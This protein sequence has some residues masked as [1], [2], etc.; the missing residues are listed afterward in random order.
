[1]VVEYRRA[2]PDD[3]AE[4]VVLRGLTRENAVPAERLA[5]AGIT[6]ESWAEDTRSGALVGHVCVVDAKIA[7]YCF[8]APQTGEV[9]VL[10]LLPP[11]EGQ[12]IGRKLLGFV[13]DDL[14]SAGFTRLFLGC[15]PDPATR[16]YGFYRHLGWRSTGT[17]NAS[18]DE[19][20]ETFV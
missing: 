11:F 12:R 15:S 4:C 5:R 18:G 20:L 14:R 10:A 17:L 7:G 3:I 2:R 9:V 19:V 8:G 16:S 1:M 13:I 6:V